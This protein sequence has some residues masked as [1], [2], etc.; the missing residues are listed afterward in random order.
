MKIYSL[1]AKRLEDGGWTG[2]CRFD[3]MLRR[4]F[5]NLRSVTGLPLLED[6]DV[7]I[8]D[9]H[10]SLEV[11][12]RTRTIVVH[13]GCARTHFDRDQAW[14][15]DRNYKLVGLQR[16]MVHMPNRVW[17]APSRWVADQFS[18][19]NPNWMREIHVI[20]HWVEPIPRKAE[21]PARPIIIGDWRDANKGA[22]LWR[23]LG[24]RN[25]QWEFQPLNFRDDAGR[26]EQ[27][28]RAS[29]YLCLSASE[30]GSYSMCDAEAAGL[31]IVTTDVGNYLEFDDCEVFP[32]TKRNDVDYVATAI[33][34][35]LSVGR[36]KPSFYDQFS[37]MDWRGAWDAA[38]RA[39]A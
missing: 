25:P 23:K 26:R 14:Q 3:S 13:H 5:P 10:L 33:A 4:V 11:P 34:R 37:F 21:K 18:L 27:Y 12:R 35:K 19:H 31:P 24:D 16:R 6:G 20:P 22:G 30:G 29:L 32:W 28:G 38:V 36:Q 2:V 39:A 1:V 8:A 7:V 9:N 17:V 15:N